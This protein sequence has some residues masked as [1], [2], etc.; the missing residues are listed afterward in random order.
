MEQQLTKKERK[1]AKRQEKAEGRERDQRMRKTK[2]MLVWALVAGAVGLA[3]WFGM[4]ALVSKEAGQ[5]YSESVPSEGASHVAEGTRV[6]YQSNPPTS[7]NHWSDPLRDGI[8]D[9]E[10]PDE[11]VVH[12]L[13]H[14]R[15]WVSYRPDV[16]QEVVEAL[17]N[18]LSGRFGIILTPRS[19]NDADIALAAWTRLDTFDVQVD[20]SLEEERILDFISRYLNKGPEYVP[21]V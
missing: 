6:A 17:G 18:L 2:K 9:T 1:A 21:Q 14:G 4:Q 3:F 19:L 7:G 11:A 12:S 16:G 20:G 10:K 5:D 13:E 8:Y 15:V